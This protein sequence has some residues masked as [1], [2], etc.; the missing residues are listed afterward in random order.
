M[1]ADRRWWN[2][3]RL[4]REIEEHRDHHWKDE[5]KG[6]EPDRLRAH[7]R[8]LGFERVRIFETSWGYS[9]RAWM[10]GRRIID[11]VSDRGIAALYDRLK[12]SWCEGPWPTKA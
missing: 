8:A 7:Y 1:K 4:E 2:D 6:A 3:G 12:C 9:I 11:H 10:P 5:A